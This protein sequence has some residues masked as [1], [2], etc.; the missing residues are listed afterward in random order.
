MK[1]PS[2]YISEITGI[3][4][5][6]A[7]DYFVSLDK[8][9]TRAV[10]VNQEKISAADFKEK[11]GY[12]LTALPFSDSCFLLVGEEKVGKTPFHH[13]GAFYVQEPGAMLPVIAAPLKKNDKVLDLCAAPG[14]KTVQAA[15]T[16]TDGFVLSN[17][18]D[19]KRAVTLA[20]NVERM[21]LKNV[22]VSNCSPVVLEKYYNGYFDVVIVDAPC[23]GEGM[24]RKEPLAA[25]N[26]SKENVLGCAARQKNILDSADKMLRSGG[27]LIYSTCTFSVEENE[28]TV[29]YLRDEYGYELVK[30]SAVT[31]SASVSGVSVPG[32]NGDYVRR[33]YP[34]N[35]IGEGQFFAV[36][37]KTS[38]N[39]GKIRE[40]R[41]I[42][43]DKNKP[44][45]EF[46]EK[47][48]N[49]CPKCFLFGNSIVSVAAPYP[50]GL[51]LISRGV[52]M[53]EIV[54]NRFEPDH[55]LFTAYGNLMKTKLY[56]DKTG[57]EKYLR[58]EE[59][60]CDLSGYVCVFYENVALGGGKASGGMLKNRYPKALR[61]N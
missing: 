3:L 55:N 17:E 34:H 57:A 52:K 33:V 26:W 56:L 46:R 12:E 58:G 18:I 36:L 49:D 15:L 20:R 38:G 35:C 10:R 37:K 41:L 16:V 31:I 11:F 32:V 45:S 5:D 47:Y 8:S 54:G 14:G 1:L 61:N 19:S 23:S 24:F 29:A 28:E 48:M 27:I 39:C 51:K 13:G 43:A 2:E 9:P 44:F 40:N 42:S 25:L 60:E 22:L 50:D 7:A 30:P 4:G 21:G 53:G 6:S 59:I